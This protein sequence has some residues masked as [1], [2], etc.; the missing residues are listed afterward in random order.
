M[1]TNIDWIEESEIR[2]F[3]VA[4]KVDHALIHGVV[5]FFGHSQPFF[6][7]YDLPAVFVF[8]VLPVLRIAAS[9]VCEDGL[10]VVGYGACG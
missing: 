3:Q 1:I 2:K 7:G 10:K 4:R 6:S 5:L 8:L 9:I